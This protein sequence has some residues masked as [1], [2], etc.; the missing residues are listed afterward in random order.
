MLFLVMGGVVDSDWLHVSVL[1]VDNRCQQQPSGEHFTD[2]PWL[3]RGCEIIRGSIS[4]C[5]RWVHNP[6]Y[7]AAD[8]MIQHL[9]PARE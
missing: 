2:W 9:L 1:P 6:F 5:E 4:S 7:R 8:Y 3:S